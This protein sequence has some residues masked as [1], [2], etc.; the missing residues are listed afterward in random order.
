M[1]ESEGG[2]MGYSVSGI[3]DLATEITNVKTGT[4]DPLIE[5]MYTAVGNMKDQGG[6]TGTSY[7]NFK[8]QMDTYKAKIDA[9]ITTLAD[10]AS[11]FNTIAGDASATTEDVDT[12]INAAFNG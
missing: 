2:K 9:M 10:K 11:G 7:N 6:W 4:V 8:S 3:T 12:A 1:A 5:D